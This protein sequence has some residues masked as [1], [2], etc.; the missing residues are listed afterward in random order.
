MTIERFQY[1]QIPDSELEVY[2]N[3]L[4][5]LPVDDDE[6]RSSILQKMKSKL[7]AV[8]TNSQVVNAE[9]L[10]LVEA[11]TGVSDPLP[12]AASPAQKELEVWWAYLELYLDKYG[13]SSSCG[14]I[15]L[16][17][18]YGFSNLPPSRKN[19]FGGVS[20]DGYS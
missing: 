20:L 16:N 13:S 3:Q 12:A 5:E 9:D 2:L 4:M 14:S 10:V 11:T 15:I 1:S 8:L 7:Q 17:I 6:K 18:L 19:Q